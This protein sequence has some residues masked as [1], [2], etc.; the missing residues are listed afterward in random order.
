MNGSAAF[1]AAL[2]HRVVALTTA[3]RRD[4]RAEGL[5]MAQAKL[6]AMRTRE[7]RAWQTGYSHGVLEGARRVIAAAG[8][9]RI[10]AAAVMDTLYRELEA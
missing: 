10:T 5:A 7:L 8:V 9:D 2:K 3:A 6:D 1:V 4:G